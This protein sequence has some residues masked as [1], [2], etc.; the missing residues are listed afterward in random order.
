MKIAFDMHGVIKNYPDVFKP[1]MQLLRALDVQV[2]IISGP[3]ISEIYSEL[4]QVHYEYDVHYDIVV[5]VV[6]WLEQS[7]A[8]L[9]QDE[10]G[11][12]WASDEDW[13]SAKAKICKELNIDIMIDDSERYESYFNGID[14]KFV[15]F[16]D[17][18]FDKML[19]E[20]LNVLE[21]N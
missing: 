9:W 5:S 21:R 18:N 11:T 19:K 13:W 14:T 15:L 6:W 1:L 4:S 7:R 3:P 2:Y 12:W 16:K 17:C 20:T 10:K 8:K